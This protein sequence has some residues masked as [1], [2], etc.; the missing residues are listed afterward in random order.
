LLIYVLAA[1]PQKVIKAFPRDRFSPELLASIAGEWMEQG[2][3]T[4]VLALLEPLF[5]DPARLDHRHAPAFDV[6]M[7]LYLDLGKPRKR[8]A[9][10]ETGLKAADAHLRG[11]ARQRQAA[12]L[13]DQGDTAGA[14]ESLHLAMRD[15][16]DDPS[17]ALLEM[18]LLQAEGRT[19]QL[20]ERAR[21]WLTRLQR[22]PQDEVVSDVVAMLRQVMDNPDA[23]VEQYMAGALPEFEALARKLA[24]LPPLGK[25]ARLKVY[26]DGEAVWPENRKLPLDE[27]LELM[28]FLDLEGALEW[29]E[30]NPTGWDCPDVLNGLAYLGNAE[31]LPQSW[32]DRM[33]LAP[34]Y[35]RARA[36]FD[37]ARKGVPFNA[38][39]PWGWLPNRAMLRLLA[40]RAD[41]LMRQGNRAEALLA[42]AELLRLNPGDNQGVRE[43]YS[44][45]LLEDGQ[46]NN[47]LA[48]NKLYPDDFCWLTYDKVVALYALGK[49]DEALNALG[50]ADKAFPKVLK[51]LVAQN[52]KQPK[53]DK[54][55][56]A[57][58]GQYEAWLYRESRLG[59]W[60]KTGALAWARGLAE[61][62]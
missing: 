20:R 51:M 32:T 37:A 49:K 8:K 10:L 40:G 7:N 13:F 33:I 26:E 56:V 17:L 12:A 47:V 41:W 2:E 50:K 60:E 30:E 58:G 6:L 35:E 15:N 46:Y 16:P 1:L 9:L 28:E 14:W 48:L 45:A 19:D 18:T 59:V 25:P 61:R 52:P 53:E 4:R 55:G 21:F 42:W 38:P 34:I 39:L 11:T 62:R 44:G 36:L 57:L 24:S 22:Q 31:S 5:A 54:Y 23:L 27:W 29:L 43:A 3:D